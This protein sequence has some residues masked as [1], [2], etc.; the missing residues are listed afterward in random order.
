MLYWNCKMLTRS[1]FTLQP[2]SKRKRQWNSLTVSLAEYT[3]S[4]YTSMSHINFQWKIYISCVL[5]SAV[6][7]RQQIVKC[8]KYDVVTLTFEFFHNCH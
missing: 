6:T 2:F 4:L 7:S 5:F 3:H 1:N 8:S